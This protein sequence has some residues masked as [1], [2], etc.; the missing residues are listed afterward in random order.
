MISLVGLMGSGKTTIGRLLAARL[1]C[2][3][4]DLDECI[5]REAGRSIPRIFAEQGEATFRALERRMLERL[6]EAHEEG[7]L[8]TGGGVV[9]DPE[10]RKRLRKA[11]P[12]IWLDAPP[13]VLA[14]R[15][16]GDANRPLIQGVDVLE[17]TMELD[18]MRRPLYRELAS[19]RINTAET[20]PESA[21]DA[22]LAFL[23]ESPHA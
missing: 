13:E 11:G 17:R 19:L 15:I 5:V 9:L 8:S 20:D 23:S 6:L 2:P 1:H 10:N 4:L 14:G 22:I 21:V 18:R 16:A 7:V 3:F 12:V